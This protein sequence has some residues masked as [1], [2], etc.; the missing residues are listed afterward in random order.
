MLHVDAMLCPTISGFINRWLKSIKK[1]SDSQRIIATLKTQ[2]YMNQ[3]KKNA[4]TNETNITNIREQRL[5][6][7][8]DLTCNL[9]N[10]SIPSNFSLSGAASFFT[11]VETLSESDPE[12]VM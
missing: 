4:A 2:N 7:F 1:L 10:I 5:V 12:L 9:L 8:L 6:F 11:K 3:L